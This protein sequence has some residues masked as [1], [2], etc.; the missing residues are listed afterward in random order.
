MTNINIEIPDEVHKELKLRA[1]IEEQ[2]L[3]T[4]ITGLLENYLEQ[5][6]RGGKA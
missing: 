4:L 5:K 2:P 3:K 1:V 6:K